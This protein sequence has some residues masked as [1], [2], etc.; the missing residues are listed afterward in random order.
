MALSVGKSR[1]ARMFVYLR[2]HP[3][4]VVAAV[5]VG[6]VAV[7]TLLDLL[8]AFKLSPEILARL[9]V[10]ALSAFAVGQLAEQFR[11]QRMS[12][13]QDEKLTTLLNGQQTAN[14]SLSEIHRI[15]ELRLT[16]QTSE[17]TVQQR[18]EQLQNLLRQTTFW[19]FR[20]GSGRWQRSTVL[21]T[22]AKIKTADI[23][24]RMQLV[25]VRN[26]DL[27]KRY[28]AYRA[29][30]AQHLGPPDGTPEDVHMDLLACV[31][32]AAWYNART[33]I[34]AEISLMSTYSP[35]R[36][37]AGSHGL[38][39]TVA[40]PNAPALFAH[41]RGWLYA[42]VLDDIQRAHEELPR[43]VLP[44]GPAA[45]FPAFESLTAKEVRDV[46][47]ATN[48]KSRNGRPTRLI[49]ET[50]HVDYG[51]VASRCFMARI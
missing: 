12:V 48:V 24:Y 2:G 13:S 23:N 4:D 43:I 7:I 50:D 32:A 26:I 1:L 27:V 39:V 18:E 33:R 34:R 51:N 41:E 9:A 20:G 37:D 28:A 46:L 15:S 47:L 10:F 35:L 49:S 29:K 38:V 8:G 45:S 21:P 31:Y 3:G 42:A 44:E 25:D 5:V 16:E 22:L 11:N 40:D 14:Q 17:L 30:Q 19:V 6:A 36:Y